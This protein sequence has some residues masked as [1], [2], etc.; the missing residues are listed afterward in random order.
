MLLCVCVCV[1]GG[2]EGGREGGFISCPAF[3]SHFSFLSLLPDI[4]ALVDW[5]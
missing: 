4:T 2:G 3:L 1:G 5:V